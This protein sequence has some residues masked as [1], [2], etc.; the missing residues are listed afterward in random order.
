ML[1][2]LRRR[3]PVWC[4][5]PSRKRRKDPDRRRGGRLCLREHASPSRRRTFEGNSRDG[6]GS[7][8]GGVSSSSPTSTVTSS[9]FSGPSST[10]AGRVS[11]ERQ[12]RAGYGG[13]GSRMLL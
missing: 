9:S 1:D 11:R 2:E 7:E 6:E 4:R 5:T 10:T 8:A 13:R 3:I 12:C